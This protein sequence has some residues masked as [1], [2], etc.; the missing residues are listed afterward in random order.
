M[1]KFEGYWGI[2]RMLADLGFGAEFFG[3]YILGH[4]LYRLE[5]IV[6]RLVKN[7]PVNHKF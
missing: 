5:K 4:T 3:E 1:L 7:Y 2:F 6:S